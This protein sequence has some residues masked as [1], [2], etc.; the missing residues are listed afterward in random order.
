MSVLSSIIE[1]VLEDLESRKLSEA[2][3]NELISSAPQVRD[4]LVSLRRNALSVIAEVK[5]SSPSKGALAEIPEPSTL[6]KK[7]ESS[8]ASV[9]SVLTEQ[10]RFGG[11][12]KD[13]HQVRNEIALPVLRKD[14]IVNEYLVKESRANGTDLLLLIVAALDDYQLRDFYTLAMELGMRVLVEVHDSAELDRALAINPEI[15][16][17]NSRNL[18]T[19]EIDL[20]N[21][22]LLLPKIPK[23]IYRV[24]ESGISESN[25]VKAAYQ[26]GANAVLVGESLVKAGSPESLI[27]DFLNVAAVN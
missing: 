23:G 22:D 13:L 26:L 20:K 7:Y 8:G 5:R 21:F 18:K 19:L 17:V 4:P 15:I 27:A 25:Q 6:A 2:Q 10:R 9:V 14:F 24:A 3:L 1:G 11:S 16:G 12:L